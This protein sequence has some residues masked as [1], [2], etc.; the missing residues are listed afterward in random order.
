MAFSDLSTELQ[1]IIIVNFEFFAK[2]LIIGGFFALSL[3]FLYKFKEAPQ[4]PYL[5]VS[6]VR[7][8]ALVL[9]A[10]YLL[11]SP[12]Y[13][14]ILYPQFPLETMIVW[15]FYGLLV[16]L[17]IVFVFLMANLVFYSPTY[18]L[19]K[20][21]FNIKMRG[22]NKVFNSIDKLLGYKND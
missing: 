14:L 10:V 2:V 17:F 9:S 21:G 20:V 12:M 1:N 22:Q 19:E 6:V 16:V 4:T 15:I 7:I 18:L 13:I 3:Y 8:A 11:F 5:L